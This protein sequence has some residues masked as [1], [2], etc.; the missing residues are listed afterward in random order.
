[1]Q[2]LGAD[3]V[4]WAR[5]VLAVSAMA[6]AS[7]L[8]PTPGGLGVAEVTIIAVLGAGLPSSSSE[9]LILAASL[10]RLAT[11]LEPVPIG[12]ASYL[13]W[14]R[15]TSWRRSGRTD[16]DAPH[17]DAPDSDTPN[18]DAPDSDAPDSDAPG[19]RSGVPTPTISP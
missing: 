1:M 10:F 11:W 17:S 18:S 15:N 4:S 19:G 14:R 13:F 3:E 9:Q 2:G 12:A 5:I 8:A 16:S 6:T 7:L